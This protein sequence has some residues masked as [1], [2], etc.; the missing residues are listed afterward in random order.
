MFVN[1][2]QVALKLE[3]HSSSGKDAST[4]SNHAKE[5]G[6]IH[7]SLQRGGFR[8]PRIACSRPY[9]RRFSACKSGGRDDL[10]SSLNCD[11]NFRFFKA[12]SHAIAFCIRESALFFSDSPRKRTGSTPDIICEPLSYER[13]DLRISECRPCFRGAIPEINIEKTRTYFAV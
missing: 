7:T 6:C 1:V 11:R 10:A 3:Y 9:C 2:P 4:M 13:R 12:T 5:W 8:Q